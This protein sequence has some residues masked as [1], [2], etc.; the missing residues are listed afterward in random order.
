[1]NRNAKN[2]QKTNTTLIT[3]RIRQSHLSSSSHHY[4]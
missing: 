2:E 4:C 3:E 1:M